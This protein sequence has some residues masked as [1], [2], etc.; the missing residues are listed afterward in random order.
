[1]APTSNDGGSDVASQQRV[2]SN[3]A[4]DT[5]ARR[6][7]R[8]GRSAVC[9]KASG[10]GGRGV[11]Q[12]KLQKGEKIAVNHSRRGISGKWGRAG[13]GGEPGQLT[14]DAQAKN[15]LQWSNVGSGG[16][17]RCR[18]RGWPGSGQ[19]GLRARQR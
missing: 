15:A 5:T 2:R 17:W 6:R 11:L 1:M 3:K 9:Q 8:S 12:E 18:E 13:E 7:R 14:N 16:G 10:G 4:A 19:G